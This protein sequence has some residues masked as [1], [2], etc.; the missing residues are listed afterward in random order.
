MKFLYQNLYMTKEYL[1]FYYF[2]QCH[3]NYNVVRTH[4]PESN[5]RYIIGLKLAENINSIL[6]CLLGVN[7]FAKDNKRHA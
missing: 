3:L 7:V 1:F 4:K 6:E 2:K 5:E